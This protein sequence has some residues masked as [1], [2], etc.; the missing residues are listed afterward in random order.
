ML[1]IDLVLTLKYIIQPPKPYWP[2]KYECFQ[3]M[4]F[5]IVGK[6]QIVCLC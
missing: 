3:L 1:M 4:C 5:K 2:N 6:I